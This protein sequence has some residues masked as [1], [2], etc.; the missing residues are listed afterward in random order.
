MTMKFY[1]VDPLD[2]GWTLAPTNT[3][4]FLDSESIRSAVW[5][6][7]PRTMD[8]HQLD[9]FV[10]NS[11]P[12]FA[13][14]SDIIIIG[15]HPDSVQEVFN[16]EDILDDVERRIEDAS[17]SIIYHNKGRVTLEQVRGSRVKGLESKATID[18]ICEHDVASILR[19]PGAELPAHPGLHYIGPNGDHYEAFLR[20]GFATQAI[21]E[22]DRLAFWLAP[23]LQGRSNILV[24]HRSMIAVAYHVGNYLYKFFCADTIRVQSLRAYD[25]TRDALSRR[26]EASFATPDPE[27]GAVLLSVNSSGR[28]ARDVLL[29]AMRDIGFENPAP[30]AIARTPSDPEFEVS[31]LTTL[32]G[33]FGRYKP[34]DCPI[35]IKG[36]STLI[37]I[38][39]DSYLLNLSAFVQTT[40]IT[41]S[42]AKVSREVV[43]RYSGMDAFSV[44]RTHSDQRHHAYHIDLLRML[45][46]NVFSRRLTETV[47]PWRNIG[48]DLIIHPD[49]NAARQLASMLAKNLEVKN[50]LC[51]DERLRGLTCTGKNAVLSACRICLV[52]DVVI[53]G[54]RVFGYRNTLNRM[55]RKFQAG[56][57]ELYCL[58][59]V[60][61][62]RHERALMGVSDMFHHTPSNPRFLSVECI[63]L[64]NWDETECPWCAE[65]RILN[66]LKDKFRE[67]RLFRDRIDDRIE[68]LSDLGGLTEELFLSWIGR[69]DLKPIKS[70]TEWPD[71]NS[72]Y[73]NRQWEL[74]AR[75]VFG[76]VQ[77]ADLAVS[78][79]AAIQRLR[80]K[81]RN[82]DLTWRE[83]EL[84]EI[85]RSPLAKVLEPELYLAGRYYEPVLV[86]A[87]LRA[88]KQHD[89]R[90]PG[91]DLDLE[92]QIKI[93]V[94]AES[95]MVLYGELALATA[96][97]QIPRS[98]F[99]AIRQAAPEMEELIKSMAEIE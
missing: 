45:C 76:E 73:A 87:I 7:F 26:L 74:G 70:I 75:S 60:A 88:A 12:S 6:P 82:A 9:Y 77:G 51:V 98:S 44:H 83:S 86:A 59:G 85:F 81:C 30:M 67:N 32:S 84:D 69:P 19:R 90:A 11:C 63:F 71:D 80:G 31:A 53:S 39:D 46:G 20:P 89:I 13:L 49:H 50:M 21:E 14:R 16:N 97:D 10:A 56:D 40:A 23:K 65:F 8:P 5:I 4:P 68:K 58:V 17:L 55:R 64:P 42:T 47:Q 33:K 28:L 61:R 3:D 95:S 91:N 2:P 79:A 43:E 52:D 93:L 36:G 37:P 78:I 34:S 15:L 38:Q 66:R 1:V 18:R 29:P 35:C 57:V 22:L 96:L 27:T 62:T 94:E 41:R 24:D 92:R 54:A 48:I 99:E 25:E 72:A